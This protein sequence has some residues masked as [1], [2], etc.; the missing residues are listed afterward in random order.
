MAGV[1][2][3]HVEG[4]ST[5][6]T[7]AA[8]LSLELPAVV[9]RPSIR[10]RATPASSFD[11]P[12][13]D[14]LRESDLTPPLCEGGP[15]PALLTWLNAVAREHVRPGAR[16]IVTC[17]GVGD[18]AALLVDR[19]YDVAAFDISSVAIEWAQRRH[20]RAHPAFCV[21]DLFDPPPNWR[22]RFDFVVDVNAVCHADDRTA[23]LRAL[24]SLMTTRG[25]LLTI[26]HACA[27]STPAPGPLSRGDLA[28][29]IA[30][31][32]LALRG[33]IADFSDEPTLG[34]HCHRRLRAVLGRSPGT[35]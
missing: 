32:G 35:R 4:V 29:A 9:V 25:T 11:A 24:A 15:C 13:I 23:H 22:G 27:D 33:E 18:D 34:G 12:Y 10:P 3:Q 26:C 31:A 20:P 14:A 16:T 5:T 28:A 21:A 19:G 6:D 1:T 30:D 2:R 8:S 7:K 17:C